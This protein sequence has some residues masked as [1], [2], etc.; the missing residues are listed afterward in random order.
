MNKPIPS[1]VQG[2]ALNPHVEQMQE[3][4]APVSSAP[5]APGA[6]LSSELAAALNDAAAGEQQMQAA[7]PGQVAK[8]DPKAVTIAVCGDIGGKVGDMVEKMAPE[9]KGRVSNKEWTDF[10]ASIGETLAFYGITI[11][12]DFMH[13]L[14]KV[15]AAGVP[16]MMAV[17]AIKQSRAEA[18]AAQQMPRIDNAGKPANAEPRGTPTLKPGAATTDHPGVSVRHMD[19]TQAAE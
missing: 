4:L 19:A 2:Q 6:A 10:G 13:P 3:K 1:T 17:I 8:V 18:A 11:S 12:D 14:F 7:A 15:A 9:M 16:I 5:G